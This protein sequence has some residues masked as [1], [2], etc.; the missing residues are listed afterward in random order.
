MLSG[1]SG[2]GAKRPQADRRLPG[3]IPNPFPL[4]QGSDTIRITC[5]PAVQFNPFDP[6]GPLPSSRLCSEAT[7]RIEGYSFGTDEHERYND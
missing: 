1:N 6:T 3:I 2:A 7:R 4:P 5:R